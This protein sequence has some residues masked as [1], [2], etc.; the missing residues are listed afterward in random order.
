M[1]D[2]NTAIGNGAL[3]S[4]TSGEGLVAVGNRAL[5]SVTTDSQDTA[6]GAN[7]L[8]SL[9]TRGGNTALG[10]AAMLNAT[11]AANCVAVGRGALL[12]NIDGDNNVAM[13][14]NA[15]YNNNGSQGEE[16]V[17]IGAAAL[18]SAVGPVVEGNTAIGCYALQWATS[19]SGNVAVGWL[20]GVTA[21]TAN[22]NITGNENTWIG[23][24]SGPGTTTQLSNSI[25]IG[26]DAVVSANDTWVVGKLG[27]KQAIAEGTNACMGLATLVAG[28]ATVNTNKVTANSRIFLTT[29]VPG[30][31]VGTPYV[32]QRT[33]GTSFTIS[34][35]TALDTSS[36]A[37]EIKE[38]A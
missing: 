21:N 11:T 13:G 19:N 16:N 3:K 28:V 34:S 37:W 10:W 24:R 23:T 30:G 29:N 2:F 26:V 25:A 14:Y 9:T 4:V 1:S 36:V 5:E 31:T 15:M 33:P 18:Y 20:A 7:S 12:S 38:P 17:A 35:T 22:A 8:R 27:T 32:W 6:V